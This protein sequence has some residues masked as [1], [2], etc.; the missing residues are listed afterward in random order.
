MPEQITPYIE[1]FY[2]D[3]EIWPIINGASYLQ[4]QF[5]EPDIFHNTVC[6]VL[7]IVRQQPGYILHQF[8]LELFIK[9]PESTDLGQLELY[10]V[11]D[12]IRQKV[13]LGLLIQGVHQITGVDIQQVLEKIK[14]QIKFLQ[15]VE[16]KDLPVTPAQLISGL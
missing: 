5:Q 11:R 16:N 14:Q 3:A 9:H 10:R 15:Q 7:P 6:I 1:Q 2:D 8:D 12:F 4:L 13:D